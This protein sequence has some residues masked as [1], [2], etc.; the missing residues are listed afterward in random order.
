MRGRY[1]EGIYNIVVSICVKECYFV[2][3]P[4][5]FTL[6][7]NSE[8]RKVEGVDDFEV[9][10]MSLIVPYCL[11]GCSAAVRHMDQCLL[12]GAELAAGC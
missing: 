9:I 2:R 7:V 11:Q 12:F 4:V 3:R 8:E 6:P 10:A 1:G 5:T